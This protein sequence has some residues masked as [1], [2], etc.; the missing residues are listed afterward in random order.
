MSGLLCI[1][2]HDVAPATWDACRRWLDQ[3][4]ALEASAPTLLLVPDFHG[5]GGFVQAPAIVDE[6]QR[7]AAAGAELAQHGLL[8]QDRAPSPRTPAQWLRRRVLTAGEGEFAALDGPAAARAL[9][10]GRALLAQ[11]GLHVRGFVPPA[12]LASAAARAA[13]REVGY[14]WTS[15]HRALYDLP[16]ALRVPAPVLAASPRSG[17]RRA[18]SRVWLGAA[19]RATH[20]API[21]RVGLHPADVEYPALLRAWRTVLRA[22]LDRRTA[23]T[24]QEALQMHPAALHEVHA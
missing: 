6:L 18:A 13:I 8:H 10:Q 15:D 24:K 16:R 9:A 22:L 7:R 17:W 1:A 21:V 3:L 12:W 23:V 11:S 20:A 2:L 14:A 19:L 5:R 4:D